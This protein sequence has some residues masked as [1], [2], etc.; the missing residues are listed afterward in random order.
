QWLDAAATRIIPQ[1][2]VIAASGNYYIKGTDP[3]TGCSSIEPVMVQIHATPAL[4]IHA[5]APIC[6]PG[7]INLAS[8]GLVSGGTGTL[9]ISQWLDAKATIPLP[10]ANA[11]QTSGTYYI[12]G[13]DMTTGCASIV[14]VTA[15]IIPQPALS[16]HAPAP[17]CAPASFNLL[18]PS[19]TAGS[20]AGLQYSYWQDALASQVLS[21]PSAIQN[22]GTY[23]I[24]AVQPANGCS[25][26]QPVTVAVLPSPTLNVQD[27][28]AVCMPASINLTAPAVT[29]GSSSNTSFSYWQDSACTLPVPHPDAVTASGIYYILAT[30]ANSCR[31]ISRVQAT[32]HPLPS[33]NLQTPAVNYICAGDSLAL[34]ASG[35]SQYQWLRN[36][37]ALVNARDSVLYATEAGTYTVRYISTL[38]CQSD[39]SKTITL[40]LLTRP[41]LQ[42]NPLSACVGSAISLQN[43]S[44][45]NHS[46]SINWQWDFG[47]GNR[48]SSFAPVHSF[49][50]PGLYQVS[51]T[52]QNTSCPAFTQTLNQSF[53]VSAPAPGIRY[54]TI[55]AVSGQS[56]A[57]Q[58]RGFGL[59]YQWIPS[60]GLSN[61]LSANPSALLTQDQDYRVLIT[62]AGG[63]TTTDSVYVKVQTTGNIYV[64]QGFTPNNDGINDRAYPILAGI[65]QLNYFRIY[66]RW[67]NLLFQTN[68][69][70]PQ[71]GWDGKY[72]GRLQPAGTYTWTA[73]GI[74]ANGN[75]LKR[76]GTILL[77]N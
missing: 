24:K 35:A 69:S 27:P 70:S 25:N 17:A 61:P 6:A 2:T 66:N 72:A 77:L 57:L 3:A 63:C 26:I 54:D 46:G 21:N 37:Q 8:P 74:D 49:Q 50:Q 33:G 44:R 20:D 48:S 67:G 65:R 30:A 36:N 45:Y 9:S 53:Q 11:I 16:I 31:T 42:F 60:T 4:S 56:A 73:E 15:Q 40:D 41:I 34:H 55:T 7:T 52:A 38:G 1:P 64:P 51:L 23:Y 75:V 58:A 68:D 39:E 43:Q 12:K 47:D 5:P 71:N 62:S 22:S 59:T 29:A 32:I 28:A 10:N 14:P 13:T 19:I 18:S 76:S